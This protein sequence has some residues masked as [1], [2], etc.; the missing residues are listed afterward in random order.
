MSWRPR[1]VAQQRLGFLLPGITITTRPLMHCKQP[2]RQT[3]SVSFSLLSQ[4]KIRC[5]FPVSVIDRHQP[6]S[7]TGPIDTYSRALHKEHCCCDGWRSQAASLG[8]STL[9]SRDV[10][11]GLRPLSNA[12]GEGPLAEVPRVGRVAFA[13]SMPLAPWFRFHT[14]GKAAAAAAVAQPTRGRNP[15]GIAALQAVE[16]QVLLRG[17]MG[18]S[19]LSLFLLAA[20]YSHGIDRAPC[21]YAVSRC[22][23]N[24]R[25]VSS[26]GS[27]M[28]STARER[29]SIAGI[30]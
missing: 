12:S 27:G 25:R 19:G 17:E 16:S 6:S 9:E 26:P 29:I 15:L 2:V 14:L 1:A 13:G 3:I 22:C 11:A 4:E 5:V 10:G 28:N 7:T 30:R 20:E 18:G 23:S 21:V 8:S 24:P